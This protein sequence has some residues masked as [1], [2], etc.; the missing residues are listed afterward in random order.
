MLEDDDG[1]ARTK[2]DVHL[3]QVNPKQNQTHTRETQDGS[4][5]EP[6]GKVS[7]HQ[8]SNH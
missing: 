7:P 5:G 3:L 2:R 4:L 8:S 1:K 6:Y